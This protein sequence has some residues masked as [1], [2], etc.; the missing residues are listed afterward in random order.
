MQAFEQFVEKTSEDGLLVYN[1]SLN[2]MS[3]KR[4]MSYGFEN[5][6]IMASVVI[7][8]DENKVE[9]GSLEDANHRVICKYIF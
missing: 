9:L 6:D 5:S 3:D 4:K 2:I 1:S 8:K 7:V